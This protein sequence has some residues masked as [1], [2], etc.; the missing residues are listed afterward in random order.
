MRRPWY[1]KRHR[2]RPDATG[3]KVGSTKSLTPRYPPH[4]PGYPRQRLLHECAYPRQEM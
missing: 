1:R 3:F 2:P 4:F